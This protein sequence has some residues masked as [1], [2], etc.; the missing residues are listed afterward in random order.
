MPHRGFALSGRAP[1][2][3]CA[4]DFKHS[5]NSFW[6][7]LMHSHAQHSGSS[8]S[9]GCVCIIKALLT[10]MITGMA[11]WHMPSP[12]GNQ[13]LIFFLSSTPSTSAFFPPP[14]HYDWNWWFSVFE[15]PPL[16]MCT[17]PG[18]LRVVFGSWI[19]LK[20]N[21]PV[22]VVKHDCYKAVSQLHS[23]FV[24][25]FFLIVSHY[26]GIQMHLI[27]KKRSRGRELSDEAEMTLTII[28]EKR[29][30]WLLL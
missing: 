16:V 2:Y 1:H 29:C 8:R 17:Q 18:S 23:I 13:T 21:G 28:S 10:H 7:S 26:K 4:W 19:L 5:P 20:K 6:C 25:F 22:V 30:W 12:L 11:H 24:F 27:S 3:Y 15:G 14:L 9:T